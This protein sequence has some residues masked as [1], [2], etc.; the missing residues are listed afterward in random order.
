MLGILFYQA[1]SFPE[2]LPPAEEYV[3]PKPKKIPPPVPEKPKRSAFKRQ[4]SLP[5]FTNGKSGDRSLEA[6]K[7]S[8]QVKE[9]SDDSLAESQSSDAPGTGTC[10]LRGEDRKSIKNFVEDGRSYV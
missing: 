7:E 4:S 3:Q 1:P 5:E 9:G 2:P 8:R 6:I 10:R